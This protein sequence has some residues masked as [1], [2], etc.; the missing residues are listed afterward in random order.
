MALFFADLVREASYGTGTG[1]LPLAGALPGHR[2]F[3]DAVPPGARFHYCIAG[4]TDPGEWETGEGEIGSGGTLI[5]LPS[6]SSSGGATVAFSAGLKTVAL[7]VGAAWFAGQEA[8]VAVG[9]VAGLQDALADKA[10][11]AHDHAGT[12]QPADAELDAIAGLAS[13]ADT[14][15]YFTGPGTA[16]LTGLSGFARSL[17]DDADAAAARATLG[18][19]TMAEQ[20]AGAVAI[21][22]GSISGLASLGTAG[23]A[24][25]SPT[26]AQFDFVSS[27]GGGA[28]IAMFQQ[29]SSGNMVFRNATAGSHFYDSFSGS[30]TWRTTSGA[31]TQMNLSGGSLNLPAGGYRIGGTQVVASRRTGWGAPTGT[32]NR[33]AFDTSTATTAALAE[34]L[35]AL[36]D[37]LTAHGLI[38]S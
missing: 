31:A 34:R 22:G 16:G 27:N 9:D 36:I 29:D 18:L 12:Y 21:T 30:F 24:V 32:A 23:V 7:T 4:V 2:R 8:G 37:D 17:I 3:A 13:A 38:G 10:D 11:A 19:G 33:T 20:S 15:P 5:R 6:A 14:L 28:K 1:D 35:K 25:S 26:H